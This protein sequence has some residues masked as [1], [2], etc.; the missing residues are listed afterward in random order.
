MYYIKLVDDKYFADP[1]PWR[2]A[3]AGMGL[4][5]AV[6]KTAEAAT[7]EAHR[8]QKSAEDLWEMEHDEPLPEA[9]P[10]FIVEKCPVGPED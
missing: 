2:R 9:R 8:R 1:E 6:W 4:G 10:H 5:C 3:R 7:E